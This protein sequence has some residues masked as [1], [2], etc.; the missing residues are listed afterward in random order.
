MKNDRIDSKVIIDEIKKTVERNQKYIL[1]TKEG[2]KNID[3]YFK[4]KIEVETK[5]TE[6]NN[7]IPYLIDNYL[8]FRIN[9]R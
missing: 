9:V 4:D 5:I 1:E 2:L 3:N 6:Y 7:K 8:K